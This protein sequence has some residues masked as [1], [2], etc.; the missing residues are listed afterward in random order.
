MGPAHSTSALAVETAPPKADSLLT[1]GQDADE[2]VVD[3]QGQD[4]NE[5]GVDV[6][7]GTSAASCVQGH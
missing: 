5:A 3:V 6:C 4:V 1:H 2:A 7:T